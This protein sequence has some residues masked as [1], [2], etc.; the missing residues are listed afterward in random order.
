MCKSPLYS[1][2]ALMPLP[3]SI[4]NTSSDHSEGCFVLRF[5]EGGDFL[6]SRGKGERQGAVTKEVVKRRV[7]IGCRR[8][9]ELARDVG[10]IV[11]GP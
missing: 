10:E 3:S 9:R 6:T 8:S 11:R 4:S 2:S 5:I 1:S 7:G